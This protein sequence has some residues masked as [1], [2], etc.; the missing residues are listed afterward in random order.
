MVSCPPPY[1]HGR[2]CERLTARVL[3]RNLFFEPALVK[4]G[5]RPHPLLKYGPSSH[6]VPP[7]TESYT[8]QFFSPKKRTSPLDEAVQVYQSR[9]RDLLVRENASHI[10]GGSPR[11]APPSKPPAFVAIFRLYRASGSESPFP[12]KEP[13][14]KLTCRAT[15]HGFQD[16][17]VWKS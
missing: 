8:Q 2:V 16:R 9:S 6:V 12:G 17:F 7:K 15:D 13:R 14:R 1:G 11:P 5:I 10:V 3:K 4:P